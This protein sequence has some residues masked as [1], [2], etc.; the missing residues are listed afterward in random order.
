MTFDLPRG[1]L[2]P[3][4]RIEVRL[5]PGQHP[6]EIENAEAIEAN[7]RREVSANPALFD[8]RTV[9]LSE[10]TYTG[11]VLAG[12]CHAVHYAT[13]LYWRDHRPTGA[14]HAFAHAALVCSDGA[15]VAIRMAAHTANPG[16]VYF[17][18]GSFEPTDVDA[19]GLVDAEG[20]MVREVREETG[21]DISAVQHEADYLLFSQDGA[22]V[23]F[24]RYHLGETAD[25]VAA[26]VAEYVKAQAQSEIEEAVI[27]R[28]RDDIPPGAM[29]YMKAFIDWHF[30]GK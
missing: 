11:G 22:S 2:V 12:R 16:R 13:L 30:G 5:D 26:R 23:A 8:G 9:L 21:L 15:L 10:L 18:A 28:G 3:V 25:R 6:W 7:W 4:S 20:N 17:A 24:R 29:P 14:E 27:I 1:R 19:D